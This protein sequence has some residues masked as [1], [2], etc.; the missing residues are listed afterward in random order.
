MGAPT[1][2]CGS[3]GVTGVGAPGVD[4]VGA[5]AGVGVEGLAECGVVGVD[6]CCGVCDVPNGEYGDSAVEPLP[7][8]PYAPGVN[9][10][11][12]L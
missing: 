7:M 2:V 10:V 6:A 11:A 4:G 3:P 8:P 1:G 9:G 12:A 5:P